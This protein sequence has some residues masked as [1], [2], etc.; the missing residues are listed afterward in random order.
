MARV[1]AC[2][3]T[4]TPVARDEILSRLGLSADTTQMVQGFARP[5]LAMSV[6]DVQGVKGRQQ[7]VNK[8][9]ADASSTPAAPK[10]T[11]IVYAPSAKPL[12]RRPTA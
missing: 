5:N 6:Q 1:L 3:A 11:A 9:W 10:G 2:T 12:R 4:A 7:A 8:L